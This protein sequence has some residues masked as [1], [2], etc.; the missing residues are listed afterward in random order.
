METEVKYTLAL[1][2]AID[3][4]SAAI[5]RGYNVVAETVGGVS[6]AEEILQAIDALIKNAGITIH[7]LQKIAVSVGP[8]S[9]TG[10]R[11]GI[12]TV[13]GF[14]R[15]LGIEVIGVSA[16][17]AIAWSVKEDS[18]SA[19]APIGRSRFGVQQFS[20]NKSEMLSLGAPESLFEDA[21]LERMNEPVQFVISVPTD[22]G[23]PLNEKFKDLRNV[24]IVG[25][26][27]A[28]AIGRYVLEAGLAGSLEPI[29]LSQ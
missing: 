3:G 15:S 4:G 19:V 16:L 7:D 24:R 20:R 29:Y 28:T 6:R 11:V 12:A 2:T 13:L 8:G 18:V 27:I 5:L 21:L 17:E 25:S 9:F 23:S 1:E 14:R 10:I 26:N 22:E